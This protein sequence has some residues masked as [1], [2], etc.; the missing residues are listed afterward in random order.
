[1]TAMQRNIEKKFV[2]VFGENPILVKSPGRVNLIGEHTDYNEGFVLPA[3]V[4]KAMYFAFSPRDDKKIELHAIDL[5]DSYQGEV[6]VLNRSPKGWPNYILGVVQ[7]LVDNKND[8]NGFNCVFGGDIPIAAGMSSS[9]ALEGGVIYGL[10]HMFDLKIDKID[11]VKMAQKAENKFVG[12]QCGI[13]DQFI[14]IF[15]EP[16]KVLKL[17]CRSLDYEYY[18][19]ERDDIKIVLCDTQVKRELATSEYNI[20]RQQCETGVSLL[21]RYYPQISS[22]RDVSQDMLSEHRNEFDPIV[23]KRCEYV[24][25]ENERVLN[26]CANLELGDFDAFGQAMFSSHDGL[27]NDYQVS[28]WELDVLV[29]AASRIKGVHGSRMMGAGFGGCTINLV[30]EDY[31]EHF[32]KNIEPVFK[33]LL[34]VE[35]QVYV[36]QIEGGTSLNEISKDLKMGAGKG[37]K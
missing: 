15:G 32:A 22:L 33:D 19:F 35:P 30:Q 16:G 3:A 8:I 11:M 10:S 6:S 26:A 17:D 2:E 12:V 31:I 20:R 24:V 29:E 13:M 18:P 28:S 9:A 25:N 27:K 7:Q 4:D 1:M 14:N 23:L 5:D 34:K 37:V 21:Q 36:T